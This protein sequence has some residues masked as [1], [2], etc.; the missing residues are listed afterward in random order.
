MA[1]LYVAQQ[2]I[3]QLYD[4]DTIHI[5]YFDK[6]FPINIPNS[7]TLLPASSCIIYQQ[8]DRSIS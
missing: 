3:T 5:E 1:A 6:I 7:D 2:G 8:I 4:T